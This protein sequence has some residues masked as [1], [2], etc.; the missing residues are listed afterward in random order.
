M[1]K[2]YILTDPRAPLEI[3]YVGITS[4]PLSERFSEHLYIARHGGTNHRCC[5]IRKLLRED[6]QPQIELIDVLPTW[7]AACE[8]EIREIRILTDDGYKLV[9]GTF[10]GDGGLGMKV[11]DLTKKKISETNKGRTHSPEA[12]RKIGEAHKGNKYC[13]GHKCSDETKQKISNATKGKIVSLETRQKLSDSHK[14]VGAKQ[15]I[16]SS[17]NQLFD[18]IAAAA[19]ALNL[20]GSNITEVCKGRRKITG[21][22]HFQY[23]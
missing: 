4:R 21:G 22:Y 14:G 18:S 1:F 16:C 9:N 12:K 5:W 17:T 8:A 2:L 6:I 13:L 7:E 19:L 11:S 20:H 3:R 23:V 15:I 10:G